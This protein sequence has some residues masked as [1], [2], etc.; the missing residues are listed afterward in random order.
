MY[1]HSMH[2]PGPICSLL[3][4]S[5][6][7]TSVGEGAHVHCTLSGEVPLSPVQKV[8]LGATHLGETA[9]LSPEMSFFD[10]GWLAFFLSLFRL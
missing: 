4:V 5:T 3:P 9:L 2:F 10:S 6:I 8:L 7:T 1:L